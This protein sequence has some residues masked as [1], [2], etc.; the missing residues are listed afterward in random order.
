M[1]QPIRTLYTEVYDSP[2]GTLLL[3]DCEGQLCLCDWMLNRARR[4][5][6]DR[7]VAAATQAVF[8]AGETPLTREAIKQLQA[9][10]EGERDSF[11]LPIWPIGSPFQQEVWKALQQIPYGSTCSYR[12]VAVRIGRPE[13]VRAVAN[14]IGANPLSL[15]IPCHRVIGQNKRLTGYAGGLEAKQQLLL[16]ETRHRSV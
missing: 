9:Y 16:L 7:R 13:A 5:R 4:E 12:D 11:T 15:L 3:G 14:A 6:I 8:Q 1:P 2:C 10:F